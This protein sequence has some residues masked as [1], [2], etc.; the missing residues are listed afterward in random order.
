MT[1]RNRTETENKIKLLVL[2]LKKDASC[3]KQCTQYTENL[4]NDI[5][6]LLMAPGSPGTRDF[7]T[8]LH[9]GKLTKQ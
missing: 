1:P 7:L 5:N 6:L 4:I 2:N 8:A 3:I 9:L